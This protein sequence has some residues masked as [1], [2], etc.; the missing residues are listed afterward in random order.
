MPRISVI[1]PVYNVENYI[2]EA[3]Q[4]ILSQTFSDFELL[5]F[6][7]LSSDSTCERISR[8]KDSRIKLFNMEMKSSLPIIKNYALSKV[9]GEY[10]AFMDGDDISYPDRFDKELRFLSEH[11]DVDVVSGSHHNFGKS[12]RVFHLPKLDEEIKQT[13]VFHTRICNGGSLLRSSIL[14]DNNIKFRNEFFVCE[15]YALWVDLM[16]CAKFANIGDFVL[17]IRV[18]DQNTTSQSRVKPYRRILRKSILDQIHR[19]IFEYLDFNM[20]EDELSLFNEFVGDCSVAEHLR[21]EVDALEELFIN[22]SLRAK[23][24][25]RINQEFWQ[26]EFDNRLTKYRKFQ[27]A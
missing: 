1:M 24:H 3:V 17:K 15:D 8:L 13:M 10:I 11:K 25:P 26:T 18:R 23:Q 22:M 27:F 12:D 7:D 16:R 21:R 5:I 9:N 14:F 19:E 2:D 20:S 6:D 4:S